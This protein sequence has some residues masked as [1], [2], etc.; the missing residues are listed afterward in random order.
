MDQVVIRTWGNS[1][2][3]RIQKSLT[4]EAGDYSGE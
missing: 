2:G 1:Q 4:E 3:I